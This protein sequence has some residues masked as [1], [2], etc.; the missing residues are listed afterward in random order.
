MSSGP[1]HLQLS[2][3][4]AT[5]GGLFS[6]AQAAACGFSDSLLHR[7][8][9]AGRF[10]RIRRGVYRLRGNVGDPNEQL[11]ALWL[12]CDAAATFVDETA[13]VL[14]GLSDVL[15]ARIH[16]ALPPPPRRVVLGANVV[17]SYREIAAADRAWAANLPVTSVRRTLLDC[18]RAGVANDI[19]RQAT[20]QAM[21]RGLLDAADIAELADDIERGR[22]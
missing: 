5:Q 22:E 3:L 21:A 10:L 12:A 17:V 7:H 11:I 14:Y 8:V 15:P 2:D 1:D 20:S 9:E 13:L 6:R 4:A 18:A 19:L 16:L